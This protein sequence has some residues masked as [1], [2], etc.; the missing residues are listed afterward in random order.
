MRVHTVKK[1]RKAQGH[2]GKCGK[3]I[4]VGDGYRWI[5]FRRGP[6]RIR[7]LDSKCGFRS[8]DMTQSDKLSR[9]YGAQEAAEDAIGEWESDETSDLKSALE[10][11]ASEIREVG[12]EYRESAENIREHFAESSTADECEEKADELEGWADTIENVEFEDS[13]EPEETDPVCP[14]CGGSMTEQTADDEGTGIWDCDNEECDCTDHEPDEDEKK[15]GEERT[16]D[17]W[18]QAM[19]ELA[20]EAI[21]ECPI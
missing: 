21:S 11:A 18:Q 16:L 13:W 5:K 4:G 19:R 15:D 2:C 1:A 17:E 20:E 8:S 10:D 3:E 7:C 6:R 9:V 14:D 12:E